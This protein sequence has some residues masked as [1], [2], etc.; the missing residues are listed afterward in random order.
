[1]NKKISI[2][3]VI[4]FYAKEKMPLYYLTVIF[5]A[6]YGILSVIPYYL[7]WQIARELIINGTSADKNKIVS[8]AIYIF[9]SQIIGIIVSFSGLM[10]SHLLAF[11]IEKNIRHNAI[12]H[13]LSL[14]IGYFENEDTGRIRR[15]ID[16]NAS[17]THTF[18]AHMFPDIASSTVIPILFIIMI[19]SIDYRLG[20]LCIAGVI[21]G[22]ANMFSLMG[23]KTKEL[24]GEYMQSSENLSINGVEFIRGIPVVKVFNQS[25]ESFQ[26]FYASIMDYDEKAKFFVNFCKKPMIFY[27]LSLFMPTILLGPLTMILIRHSSSPLELLSKSILYILMSMLL[28]SVLMKLATVSEAKNMFFIS[29]EKLN[30]IFENKQMPNMNIEKTNQEGISFENVSFTYMGKETP[31]INDISF[32]F[33]KNKTYALVGASGSGKSTLLELIGRFYDIDKGSIKIDGQDIRS[34]DEDILL[35]KLAIVFQES[36]LLKRTLR[37][38]ITMG[39]N[40]SDDEILNA[41]KLSGCEDILSNMKN[42]LDTMIGEQGTYVSGGEAQRISIARAFLRNPDILLLDE[43]TAYADPENEHKISESIEKLKQ[44]KTCIMIAHRLNSI[45]NVDKILIMQHGKLI[46]SGNHEELMQNSPYYRQ[47]YEN[48]S[49]SI[50]WRVANA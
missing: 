17:K 19:L 31:A 42:G 25:V 28:H 13:L 2:K 24:M 34:I 45:T 26:R 50:K 1:M 23:P 12:N 4:T 20:L 16:D 18:I 9:I 32:N 7:I 44:G 21:I 41:I 29:I 6:I 3:N 43:A 30:D 49:K 37:E 47:L 40:Y 14:P 33:E 15:M 27:T 35:S 10:A 48:Y 38:N 8:Y 46:D 5:S 36:K 11:R 22:M 39:K